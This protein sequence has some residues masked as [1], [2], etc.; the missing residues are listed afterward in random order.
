ML[1]ASLNKISFLLYFLLLLTHLRFVYGAV[2]GVG[3]LDLHVGEVDGVVRV[4]VDQLG[5]GGEGLR[6]AQGVPPV[7]RFLDAAVIDLVVHTANT[8]NSRSKL[9]VF[10]SKSTELENC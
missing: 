4:V 10:R 3:E 7:L 5:D 8:N 1:S 9:R 6:V 2:D